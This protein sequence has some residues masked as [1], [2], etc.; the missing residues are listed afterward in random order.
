MTQFRAKPI[1]PEGPLPYDRLGDDDVMP[2]FGEN[3]RRER[4]M[5]AVTLEEM[6]ETTKISIRLLRALEQE[7]F[8]ELP[9]GVFTRSFIRAYAQY[10][11]L[12]EE[13]VLSEYKRAAKPSTDNDLSR[14]TPARAFSDKGPRT[15][16]LPWVI[17]AAL[18]GSGYAVY[19][20]SRRSLETAASGR[21]PA[22]STGPGSAEPALPAATA[23]SAGQGT[24]QPADPNSPA[25]S[26]ATQNAPDP[27]ASSAGGTGAESI[28]S[29][30]ANEG[31]VAPGSSGA[32]SAEGA[33]AGA[34]VLGEGD[35]VL[36]LTTSEEAWIAVAA[37]GKTL[38]Q[39]RLPAN[40]VRIFRAKDGF[41]V[42]TGNAQ[43]TVL[44]FNGTAQRSLGREGE[45]KRI[46][47][48]RSSPQQNPGR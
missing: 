43:G 1:I 27:N 20:Y 35:M 6:S 11:G 4:E 40:S 13:H 46:H 38:L 15:R 45:F 26:N 29:G 31:P 30:G 28:G 33:N 12:D 47:L 24:N 42:T 16:V 21:N 44:T 32:G 18:V 37:D 39:H 17:I 10:L 8:A 7:R 34:Q 19:R 36:Q 5:R 14:L 3:L 9:G 23:A 22:V 41:D 2:S 25:R 48:A